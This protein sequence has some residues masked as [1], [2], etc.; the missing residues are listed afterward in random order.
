ME[1]VLFTSI[2]QG[3]IHVS[4][5]L[6]YADDYT[7]HVQV[8][9]QYGNTDVSMKISVRPQLKHLLISSS[10][11][12]PLVKQTLLLE[13]STEPSTYAVVYTWDFGDGSEAV[14][15]VH[16]KVS[17]TFASA[18]VY[19][20]TVCANNTL[21]VLNTWLMVEAM[22][23]ITGLTISYSGPSEVSSA[24][25]FRAT[26]ASGTSLMWNFDFGDGSLLENLTDGLTSH[27][28]KSPG[29]YTVNVA[30]SNS[31]SQAHQS[32]RVEVYRLA[33]HGV[34]PTECVMSG[35]DIQLTALVNGNISI[36]T[37]H[38]L[39][40]DGSPLTVV[41]GQST[42]THKFQ[43][44]GIFHISLTV[45]SSVTSVSLNTTLCVEVAINNM[46]VQSS[47]EVVA[48][49][50]EVCFKV[51]VF[52]EQKTGYHL[53]WFSSPSSFITKT[54]NTQWCFI[55]K[56]EGVEEV[57]VTASNKV[58]NKT[59]KA[60]ITIQ[61]PV[62]KLSVAHDS[63]SDTVTVNTVASFWV[64]SCTGSNVSVLW[65]FGDGSP[66]E[67]KQNVS[68]VFTSTG[69]FT[70]TATAFNAVSRDSVTL[71]VNV[72]LPV[73]DL[74][75]HTNQPYAVVG[76]ET[77]FSAISSAISSTNYYWTVDGVN[78]TKQ[79]TYQFRFVF[80]KPGVYQVR[81]IAQNLVSRKE[82]AILIEVFERLEGLQI[83]CQSLTNMKY[84]P[85][86]ENLLFIASITKGS[87][88]T[89]HWLATQSG[90]NRQIT[91][92]GELF[93]M[94]AETPG[95]ISVHLRASNK[96]G[97]ATS[98][99]SLVAVQRVTNAHIT[100]QSN[101]VALGKVVNISVSVIAGSDLQYLWYVKSDQSPLQTHVPFLLHTFT[102]VG[103]CL[104]KVSVQNVLSQSNVTKEFNV[105][106]EV[107][108]VD[109]V[110]EAKTHPFYITTTAAVPLHGLIRKGSD[111]HWNW[112]VR[113]A[114]TRLFNVTKQT[115]IYSF[116]CAGIYHVSLNV[117]NGINW[118]MVSHSVTVQDEIKDLMLNISKSSSCTGEQ[119]TFIPTISNG[120]NGSFVI[121]FR[122]Q[123]WI[124]SP[125]I[126]EGQFTTSS[127]PAGTHLI[128]VK[129]WNQ[130]SS[131]EVSS[132]ILVTENIQGLRLVNCCSAALE[133][134]KGTQFK[135]EIQ[136]GLPVNY[137]W[138]FHLVGF[139]PIWLRGQEVIFTPPGSGSLSVSV[140][141]TNGVC[142][143]MVND[144]ATVQLP[145]KK[146]RLVCHSEIIF[147][148][149]AVI[150]SAKV[151]GGSKLS[152]LWDF[153]DS[154]EALVT[155]LSTV[156]HT[157]Y[158]SGKYSVM[159]KVLNSVSHVST[160]LY[161]VV[162]ELQCSSPQA[163]LLQ[164]QS[165][166]FRSRPSFFEA[167][168]DVNCS[169]YK[170]RYLWD[171]L[172]GSD[173]TNS[174]LKFSGNKARL[175]GQGDAT[176]PILL[177]PKHTLDVGQYCLVFT[178]SLQGTPLLVQRKTTIT[179]VNSPLVAVIKGGSKR[180]WPSLSNL[181]LDGSESQDPDIE[182][183]EEDKLQYDWTF[184][185][186]VKAS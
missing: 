22:E 117:S 132:S 137:T 159:V 186:L 176:S 27:I 55:F 86:H 70:V 163:S 69:Q 13:A 45:L 30:V 92:D 122:N 164:S 148:G 140:L 116:P 83:E 143:K 10:L 26:V 100:T 68:H 179:V 67:Q 151:N 74:S 31:V 84:V 158:I 121:T 37:F 87:N 161:M 29:N 169:A 42:A 17:H 150:F 142:S 15:D 12:M 175:R 129:A 54:E 178:V 35:R 96:L 41:K 160:Q 20:I 5:C 123:D 171:I 144:T 130:V 88:V 44:Q 128:T 112:K 23:K 149:H 95:G 75:L 79:G 60:S 78:S 6:F 65:D 11:P 103:Y 24:T 82:A 39:F 7:L 63:Q 153:G 97:E 173:C 25:D 50:E 134:L 154:T 18:G 110:I 104:V 182:P 89:Y 77:I 9:S 120:S 76:E 99:V 174:N 80:L 93:Q 4:V 59:A 3:K 64:A 184:M 119:V 47:Q 91:G 1:T 136:S 138:I 72:L 125:G 118:Q 108:E 52:P 183:G 40:G 147:V 81:V 33:V 21:T 185:T 8:S 102:S 58:S 51:L 133:A 94:L 127:L 48:V 106:E 145:V 85:T 56:D 111:L 177:L 113:G 34:L 46:T 14:Q 28:F 101:T 16:R 43:T 2:Y 168:V 115:F 126:L 152:F 19:N 181:I 61:N 71:K 146:V 105:Q 49:G 162:E 107:Q 172:T 170:T 135:A 124:Y 141:A 66:L 109:F 73:S 156:N 57:S 131:A 180:L 53:K 36:L 165:T 167:S 90:I 114:T 139:E 166:I 157:Y 62:K 32:I 155:D 38:W 98:I